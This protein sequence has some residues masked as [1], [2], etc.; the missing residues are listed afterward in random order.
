MRYLI[1]NSLSQANLANKRINDYMT[2]NVPGYN[3]VRWCRI[4]A[5]NTGTKFAV[6]V[7]E[8]D[9]RLP[10]NA[11]DN[12][13]KSKLVELDSTWYHDQFDTVFNRSFP[14]LTYV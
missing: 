12:A 13:V 14:V 9:P 2:A 8:T 11:F 3:A 1:F 10:K 7:K 4:I 5:N 6:S